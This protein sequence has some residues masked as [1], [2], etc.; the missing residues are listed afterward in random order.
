MYPPSRKEES[1]AKLKAD[2]PDSPE[3]GKCHRMRHLRIRVAHAQAETP[4]GSRGF[5]CTRSRDFLIFRIV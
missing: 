3:A 1:A 5:I 4:D 2:D